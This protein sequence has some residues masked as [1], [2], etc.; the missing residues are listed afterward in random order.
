MTY[1]HEPRRPDTTWIV[2][3][4]R[5]AARFFATEKTDFSDLQEARTLIHAEGASHSR[6]V[7]TD[8][9]GRFATGGGSSVAGDPETDFRHQ[10]ANAF[11]CEVVSALEEGRKHNRFGRVIVIAPPL[12]LGTLRQHVPAPL[13][14]LI[15]LEINKE[16][17][18]FKPAR[19][20]EYVRQATQAS[21]PSNNGKP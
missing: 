11:A 4:D 16:L 1:A 9:P 5:A 6:D 10:T 12:F 13:A 3:A 14:K 7:V 8:R 20:A 2:V 17:V 15:D 21:P 18:Q 19:I